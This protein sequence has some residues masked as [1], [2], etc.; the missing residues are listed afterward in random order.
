MILFATAQAIVPIVNITRAARSIGFRP[1]ICEKEAHDGWN[2]VEHRRKLVPHQKAWMAVVPF[3]LV[4][5][6]LISV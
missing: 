4:A 3:K 2:T 1:M 6:A 5:I